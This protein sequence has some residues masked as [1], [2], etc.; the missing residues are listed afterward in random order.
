MPGTKQLIGDCK[1]FISGLLGKAIAIQ[2]KILPLPP[3]VIRLPWGSR[4]MAGSDYVS[5][6]LRW[7]LNYE[8][9][10]Q[11]F[12]LSFLKE[13][14]TV[15]DIGAHHGFYTLLASS[16]IGAAGRVIA[17]EPSPRELE[18]LK[19]HLEMNQCGNVRTENIA[20]GESEG[21]ETLYVCD[22]LDT[23][24]NSL[25][26]PRVMSKTRPVRVALKTLDNYLREAAVERVD[27]IKMDVE[28][29][30]WNVLKGARQ[31]LEG[32]GRPVILLELSDMRSR[33]WGYGCGE[34][35]TF[36]E[37]KKYCL[38]SFDRQGYLVPLLPQNDYNEN[39]LAVPSERLAEVDS[40]MKK[41]G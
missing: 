2:Q 15:L 16:K 39:V 27:F 38:F 5:Q 23:G 33:P 26:P 28:G 35:R 31:L 30:E 7:G 32:S 3:A 34:L 13:G 40:E 19:Q 24:C 8:K 10:E 22:G 29:G 4:W 9:K 37:S 41:N 36:L 11:A 17:F 20:L 14:W 18:R 12:L 25:R 21:E 6:C 1:A